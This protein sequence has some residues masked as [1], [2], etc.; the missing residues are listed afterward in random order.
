[1]ILKKICLIFF[2][3]VAS[4]FDAYAQRP[5]IAITIDDL[6]QPSLSEKESPKD[7]IEIHKTIRAAFA[8][9]SV[10]VTAFVNSS[11]IWKFSN[12]KEIVEALEAWIVDGHDLANHTY[13]HKLLSRVGVQTFCED[14]K[15]GEI[16][17]KNLMH[18]HHKKL[19]FFRYPGL[20]YGK[21]QNKKQVVSYLK[22]QGYR[23]APITVDSEDWKFNRLL[24]KYPSQKEKI[25]DSYINYLRTSLKFL[26][27][28]SLKIFKNSIPQIL[29]IHINTLNRLALPRMLEMLHKEFNYQFVN[30]ADALAHP[31]HQ[32]NLYCWSSHNMPRYG[33]ADF[34][35]FY[36]SCHK[37]LR[38]LEHELKLTR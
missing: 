30:L 10:P 20:D 28:A 27:E 24:H 18:K 32:N 11:G 17:I 2:G 37:W 34:G 3:I 21:G 13:G 9:Y 29:L 7:A 33:S 19:Q 6:P 12:S 14:V 16:I 1:M 15:N 5:Q 25:I 26:E 8:K 23:V 4:F 38:G 35:T 22:A 36:K 31:I